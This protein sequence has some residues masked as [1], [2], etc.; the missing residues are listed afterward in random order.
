MHTAE[1]DKLVTL[2]TDRCK[3]LTPIYGSESMEPL[4]LR[5]PGF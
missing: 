3:A 4:N 2:I 5:L 1:L